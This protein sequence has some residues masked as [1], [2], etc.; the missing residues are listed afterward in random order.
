MI[1]AAS[2]VGAVPSFPATGLGPLAFV[3]GVWFR[4][5]AV[6]GAGCLAGAFTLVGA[7]A[8]GFEV[9]VEVGFGAMVTA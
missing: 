5:T 1:G 7:V 2:V 4:C 6:V 9:V 8:V 3:L